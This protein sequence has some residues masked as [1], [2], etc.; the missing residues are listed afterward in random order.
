[1]QIVVGRERA[2]KIFH[3]QLLCFTFLLTTT[4]YN[5]ETEIDFVVSFFHFFT[6]LLDQQDPSY[7]FFGK[8]QLCG[9]RK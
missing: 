6:S 7:T 8:P 9:L 2:V 5:F 1:M 3:Q 4:I